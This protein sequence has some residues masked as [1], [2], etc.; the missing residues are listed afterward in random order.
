MEQSFDPL[1]SK[2]STLLLAGPSKCGKS[3]LVTELLLQR[4]HVFKEPFSRIV[5]CYGEWQEGYS[6]LQRT[7]PEITFHSGLPKGLY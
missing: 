2:S 5:W 3:T 7:I 6:V 4:A 1:I